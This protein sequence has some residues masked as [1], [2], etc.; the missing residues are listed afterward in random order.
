MVSEGGALCRPPERINFT[1]D[2]MCTQ[3]LRRAWTLA[4]VAALA[5]CDGLAPH[6]PDSPEI[7]A[8]P[9]AS[10]APENPPRIPNG[11]YLLG[12]HP[13]GVVWPGGNY[14]MVL[15]GSLGPQ[16]VFDFEADSAEVELHVSTGKLRIRGVAR[17]YSKDGGVWQLGDLWAI[18]FQYRRN[19]MH[20]DDD[21]S[22]EQGGWV[23]VRAGAPDPANGGT[24]ENLRTGAAYGLGTQANDEGWTF[25]LGDEDGTGHRLDGHD[26]NG[27]DTDY[28]PGNS[29]GDDGE[30]T[31][32]ASGWG[33]VNIQDED[34]PLPE[35]G[36]PSDFLFIIK[37]RSGGSSG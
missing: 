16:T 32:P 27:Y 35:N 26:L 28:D 17:A 9:P 21:P 12:N 5:A 1:V 6:G 37:S 2:V 30:D 36:K 7:A 25:Q 13:D 19:L 24:L 10:A 33:W 15:T 20:A 18:E 22:I 23:D 4:L 11:R 29:G 3:V 14:G 34:E 8:T 31:T